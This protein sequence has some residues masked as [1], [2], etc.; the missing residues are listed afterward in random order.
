MEVRAHFRDIFASEPHS[1]FVTKGPFTGKDC[2]VPSFVS[3][4]HYAENFS[5]QWSRFRDIQLDSVNGTSISREY[6]EQLIG[7]PLGY[8][9]GKTILEVGAGAGR[10]TEYLIRHASLVVAIDLSE[11]IFV[12]AG[13]E[14]KV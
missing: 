12:N 8:L 5:K 11:A 14:L 2:E 1:V 9:A 3:T 13:P 7:H 6:L 4:Q 10:F